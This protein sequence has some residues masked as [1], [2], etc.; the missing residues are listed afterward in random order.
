LLKT[1]PKVPA[2][3]LRK[4]EAALDVWFYLQLLKYSIDYFTLYW[5]GHEQPV[6]VHLNAAYYSK[7]ES[8][9]AQRVLLYLAVAFMNIYWLAHFL[10][11]RYEV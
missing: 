2:A 10:L 7:F 9:L 8:E 4:L 1:N 6:L 5:L 11:F 3:P